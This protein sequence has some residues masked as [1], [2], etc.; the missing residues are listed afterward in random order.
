MF[1]SPSPGSPHVGYTVVFKNDVTEETVMKYM[2][3]VV[4]AGGRLTQS[5]DWF[6]NVRIILVAVGLLLRGA[7][8]RVSALPFLRS[9]S[10]I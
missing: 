6:L 5:Y 4:D 1:A 10:N 9:I 7:H 3:D 8:R 2:N